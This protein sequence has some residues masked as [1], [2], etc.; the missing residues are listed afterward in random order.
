MMADATRNG[1]RLCGV[2]HLPPLPSS[3]RFAG[4]FSAVVDAAVA[5]A[6][7]LATAGF[8]G[9]IVENYGDAPFAREGVGP[10]TIAAMTACARAVA[11]AA[12]ELAL[13]INVLRNDAAAALGIAAATGAVLVRINVHAGARLTDQGIVQG[14]A[15]ET[16]RLRR[17]LGLEAVELW[18][19]VAVKHS[20]SLADRPLDEEAQELADRALADAVLL[21]GSATGSPVRGQDLLSVRHAVAVKVVVASGMT[22]DN[23]EL[24]READGV[25]VGSS[26][27]ASGRAGDPIDPDRAA[28]FADRYRAA[29]G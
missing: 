23:L 10:A 28:A 24:A 4:R 17:E 25:V 1:P 9:V 12:P 11:E 26:L 27:R 20:A 29:P 19:D 21:T 18:C 5:D 7:T 3:P 6:R 8:D 15:Y 2:I 16:L 13:G 14:N 22:L